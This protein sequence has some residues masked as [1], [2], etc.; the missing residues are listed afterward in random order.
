[1][2]R[3]RQSQCIVHSL[4][5]QGERFR[6]APR[7]RPKSF[8]RRPPDTAARPCL[9]TRREFEVCKVLLL[10]AQQHIIARAC[11]SERVTFVSSGCDNY[12]VSFGK[13]VLNRH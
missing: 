4:T 8:L 10:T 1:M 3:A 11:E 5:K 7:M 2:T 9:W 12:G 13:K 6:P